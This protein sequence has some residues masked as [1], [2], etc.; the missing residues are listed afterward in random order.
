MIPLFLLPHSRSFH[1]LSSLFSPGAAIM[2]LQDD[3]VIPNSVR[4][5]FT[6]FS[7]WFASVMYGLKMG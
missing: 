6:R 4:N 5:D 2:R 7:A 3:G 1:P